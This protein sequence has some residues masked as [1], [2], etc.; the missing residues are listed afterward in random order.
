MV[1]DH[2]SSSQK[3]CRKWLYSL[4]WLL[5]SASAVITFLGGLD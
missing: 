2:I 1:T 3:M 5:L 4:V